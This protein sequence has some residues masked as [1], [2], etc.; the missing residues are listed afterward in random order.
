MSP[1]ASGFAA[2]SPCPSSS[3]LP[4]FDPAPPPASPSADAFIERSVVLPFATVR[5]FHSPADLR[6]RQRHTSASCKVF[7]GFCNLSALE[8]HG[9]MPGWLGTSPQE[10]MMPTIPVM[11]MMMM[12]TSPHKVMIPTSGQNCRRGECQPPPAELQPPPWRLLPAELP[13]TRT[14][15]GSEPVYHV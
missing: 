12:P 7:G 14:S 2:L 6:D 1:S 5:K 9:R 3:S 11:M 8:V 4:L 15:R 13:P 10:V